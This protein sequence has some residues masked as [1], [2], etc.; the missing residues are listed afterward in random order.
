MNSYQEALEWLAY[1]NEEY[2][3]HPMQVGLQHA[4]SAMGEKKIGNYFVDGYVEWETENG[5]VQIAYDY[6]GCRFHR[7]PHKCKVESAQ[8]EEDFKKEQIRKAFLEEAVTVY[9]VIYGCEWK[10]EKE[11]LKA[12]GKKIASK[13]TPFFLQDTVTEEQILN[14]V[15]DGTFYGVVCLDIETPDEVIE[16]YEKLK[17]PLIFNNC[18]ISEE[19]LTPIIR[20]QAKERKCKFP[21]KV[22]SL[23]WNAEG[24]IGCSPLLQ[25][26]L[27][28]GMKLTNVRWALQYQSDR[29]FSNFVDSLVDCRIEAT[30]SKNGPLSD[31]CKFVLNSAVGE[32]IYYII[33]I[34]NS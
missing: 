22:K 9:N 27:Q 28:I 14:A 15:K 31:R 34:K 23:C 13:I 10:K 16:K 20:E 33:L 17:F 11:K 6:N 29:P 1:V 4:F 25:F 18:E 8:S 24:Y 19:M 30:R 2:K 3:D 5:T 26:Y 7:C 21:V 12:K 32:K